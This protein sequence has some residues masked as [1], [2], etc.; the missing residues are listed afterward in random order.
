MAFRVHR[1]AAA[2]ADSP[3]DGCSSRR[4]VNGVAVSP[5]EYESEARV[6]VGSLTETNLDQ[7]Q[8]HQQLAQTYAEVALTTPVLTRVID[9]LGWAMDPT[10]LVL[11]L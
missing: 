8:A 7:L 9:R 3:S 11:Q 2:L 5:R 4:G 6:L 10:E 1:L